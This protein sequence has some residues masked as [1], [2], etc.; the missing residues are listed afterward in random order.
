[1]QNHCW[2]VISELM[3]E[4]LLIPRKN[5]MLRKYL[6]K[7]EYKPGEHV[8]VLTYRQVSSAVT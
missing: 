1:M 7:N 4:G 2:S 3:P 6:F 5:F 8:S